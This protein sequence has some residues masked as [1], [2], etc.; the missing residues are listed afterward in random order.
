MAVAFV[1]GIA[2]ILYIMR[3]KYLKE[4]P[5]WIVNHLSLKKASLYIQKHYDVQIQL[6][7]N[8][9]DVK[10]VDTAK[11]HYKRLLK[12][13]YLKRITLATA[14]STLQGMQYYAV[15]LYIPIIAKYM[16]SED[17]LGVLLGTGIVNIAGIIG[18]YLGA[19][20][21]YRI[22]TRKLTMIG[23]AIVLFVMIMTGLLYSVMPM[24]IN[25]CLIALFLFGHAGGPGTQGKTIGAMSFPTQLRSQATG[26]VESVSRTGSIIGT[27]IFPIILATV[28][29]NQT[30]LIIGLVPLIG[31]TITFVL[32]WEPV[33]KNV[34]NE[35]SN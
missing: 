11:A 4:S 2:L 7:D 5:T 3:L 29:L 27:F 31:L 26:I 24:I 35:L 8:E 34:E 30:M 32:K 28:G 15:G 20:Y 13:P 12:P 10:E 33:G 6:V 19:Q 14:I 16:I 21:T 17:K 22:G 9:T 23:F 18:A 1:G 25:S